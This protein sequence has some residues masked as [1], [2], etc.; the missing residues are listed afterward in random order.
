MDYYVVKCEKN[1]KNCACV[2]GVDWIVDA[3]SSCV[4]EEGYI[5]Q[6]FNRYL[7]PQNALKT[8][9]YQSIEYY[10]AWHVMKGAIL[11]EDRGSGCDDMYCIGHP[12]CSIAQ[13]P[14]S[15]GTKGEFTFNGTVYW[16]NKQSSLFWIVDKWKRTDVPQTNGLK[17]AYVFPEILDEDPLFRRPPFVHS[18]DLTTEEKIYGA[19]KESLFMYC[20]SNSDRDQRILESTARKILTGKY[21]C[22][23]DRIITDW[24]EYQN[25]T[26]QKSG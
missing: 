1:Y 6:K 16:I 2:L 25:R 12:Q 17:G 4:D 15:L 8:Q 7:N 14:I 19:V 11:P 5:V 18:W 13:Y 3:F 21:A 20:P 9:E 23:A 10:E 24:M 26:P 22:I